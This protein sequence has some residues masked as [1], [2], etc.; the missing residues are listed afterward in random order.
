MYIIIISIKSTI[1]K[2][3]DKFERI[4]L[5]SSQA[6][7]GIPERD[8]LDVTNVKL[9]GVQY[10]TKTDSFTVTTSFRQTR[11]LTKKDLE[12]QI[13]DVYDLLGLAAPIFIFLKAGSTDLT[14]GPRM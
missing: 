13:N 1:C 14:L 11:T 9:L 7:A 4:F 10:N 8:R 5:N 3:W 6:S 12:S 2:D